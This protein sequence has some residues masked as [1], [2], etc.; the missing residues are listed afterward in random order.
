[1]DT[2]QTIKKNF[3]L[4]NGIYDIVTSIWWPMSHDLVRYN[5]PWART[6]LLICGV[7]RLWL[8]QQTLRLQAAKWTYAMGAVICLRTSK[9]RELGIY[10]YLL[11]MIL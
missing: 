4:G 3:V 11:A 2:L 6:V 9:T 1:M 8:V 7:L 5:P 10:Y